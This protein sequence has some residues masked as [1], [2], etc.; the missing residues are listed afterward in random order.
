MLGELV[1]VKKQQLV[2]GQKLE[3]EVA[4]LPAGTYL[5]QLENGANARFVKL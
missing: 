2:S 1:K 4:D 3:L 5:I